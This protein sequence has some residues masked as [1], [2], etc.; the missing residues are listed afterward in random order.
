MVAQAAGALSR[1]G[2]IQMLGSAHVLQISSLILQLPLLQMVTSATTGHKILYGFGPHVLHAEVPQL[3][4]AAL[5]TASCPRM[6]PHARALFS[7]HDMSLFQL[8]PQ[9]GLLPSGKPQRAKPIPGSCAWQPRPPT[10]P[11]ASPGLQSPKRLFLCLVTPCNGT[12]ALG[13]G[14]WKLR[15]Q[16]QSFHTKAYQFPSSASIF[17]LPEEE[18]SWPVP[19]ITPCRFCQVVS[20]SQAFGIG[21]ADS[22]FPFS[23]PTFHFVALP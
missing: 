20:H 13:F 23:S 17:K 14:A 22:I 2:R 19:T 8:K 11:A 6:L 12:R 1:A 3:L 15:L 10:S 7:S 4:E 5:V 21:F 16:L 18:M 9:L